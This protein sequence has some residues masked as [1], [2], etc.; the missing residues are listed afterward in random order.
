MLIIYMTGLYLT[1]NPLL[2]E[3]PLCPYEWQKLKRSHMAEIDGMKERYAVFVNKTNGDYIRLDKGNPEA[4]GHEKCNHYHR[5]NQNA[6]GLRNLYLDRDKNP[7]AKGDFTS[8]LYP[9]EWMDSDEDE[10]IE[11]EKSKYKSFF[12]DGEILAVNSEN[13]DLIFSIVS[14]EV[15]EEDIVEEDLHLLS[16]QRFQ[17]KLHIKNVKS[18]AIDGILQEKTLHISAD[19][20]DIFHCD[21]S[22]K[23]VTFHLL[24]SDIPLTGPISEITLEINGAKIW[25]ENIPNLEDQYP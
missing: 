14:P 22:H 3:Q 6:T 9:S 1:L 4:F 20:V 25:W 15:L 8:Y 2:M 13:Q 17:G 7:V 11:P 16:N 5:I 19:M 21:I 23:M 18:L 12:H 24:L 10:S